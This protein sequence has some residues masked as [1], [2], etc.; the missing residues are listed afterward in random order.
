MAPEDKEVFARFWDFFG[1]EEVER[2][3]FPVPPMDSNFLSSEQR[4]KITEW[5][6]ENTTCTLPPAALLYRGS[7]DGW[8]SANFHSHCDNKGP[9]VTVIRST[10]G[11]IFGGYTDQ[12]WA[13]NGDWVTSSKAFL[14]VL[15]CHSGLDPTKMPLKGSSNQHAHYNCSSYGPTFGAGHDLMLGNNANSGNNSAFS[16]G[17]TYQ[18][19]AGQDSS[20]F[21]T[22]G[23]YFQVDEMEV[24]R[25]VTT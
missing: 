4:T 17:N 19:P 2:S 15:H 22:G 14:F 21:L 24:L 1:L 16:I 25:L 7:R 3:L 8:S 13:S 10:G 23:G 11:Y 18:C 9:T 20:T 5:I 6:Q 12:P